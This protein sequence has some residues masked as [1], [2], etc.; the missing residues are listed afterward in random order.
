MFAEYKSIELENKEN[1]YQSISISKKMKEMEDENDESKA[2]GKMDLDEFINEDIDET[3]SV[4]MSDI[5]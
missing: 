4:N 3:Q 2:N 1:Y 5:D